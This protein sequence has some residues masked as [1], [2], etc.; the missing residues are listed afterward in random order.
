MDGWWLKHLTANGKVARL[1][2]IIAIGDSLLGSSP[3]YDYSLLPYPLGQTE[4][5]LE[6][7]LQLKDSILDPIQLT[8]LTLVQIPYAVL[9]VDFV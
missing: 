1:S 8:V 9:A 6:P 5:E 7:C 3:G 4:R 2:P